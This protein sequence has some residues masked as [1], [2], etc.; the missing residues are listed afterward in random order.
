VQAHYRWSPTS[1]SSAIRDGLAAE[2]AFTAGLLQD[3]GLLA[4]LVLQSQIAHTHWQALRR[5]LPESQPALELE[6]FGGS[7]GMRIPAQTDL[8]TLTPRMET[9]LLERFIS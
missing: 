8:D 9:C 6:L 3:F 7:L 5:A 2:D 4:L 1:P